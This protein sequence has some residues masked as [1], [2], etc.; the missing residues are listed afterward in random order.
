MF[1]SLSSLKKISFFIYFL[2][3]IFSTFLI[4]KTVENAN[5]PIKKIV[6][7]GEFKHIDKEQVDLISNQ[8]IKSNFFKINL[9]KIRKAFK[10]LPWVREVSIKRKWP[11]ELKV[12]IEEHKAIARWGKIGLVNSEGEIFHAASEDKLPM[13]IGP[14]EFVGEMTK[15][16]MKINK[17]LEEELMQVSIIALSKRLSW[18]ISTNNRMKIILGKK[19][20][21]NKLQIFIDNYQ[22]ALSELKSTI[23]YVDLRYR[24]GFSVRRT[25]KKYIRM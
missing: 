8:Y 6:I 25:N 9:N 5:L 11:D 19:D 1:N 17:I 18:E 4:I 21:I 12:V 22:F 24:D 15:K 10:K 14:V 7:A 13:F 16:Y 20:I 3:F 2:I 23:E